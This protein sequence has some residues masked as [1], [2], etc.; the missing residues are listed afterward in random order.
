MR[1]KKNKVAVYEMF[2][3][4]HQVAVLMRDFLLL[5]AAAK[6][7]ASQAVGSASATKHATSSRIAVKI[8]PGL[9]ATVR[10]NFPLN[11][12]AHAAMAGQ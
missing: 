11:S 5:G 10:W 4:L 8:L 1:V 2:F 9:A 3:Y 12:H 6:V 7:I